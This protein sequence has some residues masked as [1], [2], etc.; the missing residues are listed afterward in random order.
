MT[1]DTKRCGKKCPKH[2]KR[3]LKNKTKKTCRRP[4]D[5]QSGDTPGAA[6]HGHRQ[7]NNSCYFDDKEEDNED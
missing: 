3:K 2:W 1:I 7:G 4:E 5:H 6:R